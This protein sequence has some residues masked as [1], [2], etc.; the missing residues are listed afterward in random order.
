MTAQPPP[1]RTDWHPDGTPMQTTGPPPS[2]SS[3]PA[4]TP[5]DDRVIIML[6]EVLLNQDEDRHTTTHMF[7]TLNSRMG[8]HEAT[9]AWLTQ[10]LDHYEAEIASMNA[11]IDV[12]IGEVHRCCSHVE[13]KTTRP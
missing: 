7:D 6:Q 11:R 10:R 2:A 9:T 3:G 5:T 4:D 8:H 1:N 13:T 12:R